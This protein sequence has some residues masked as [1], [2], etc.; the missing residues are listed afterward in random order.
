MW[1]CS[2]LNLR[3]LGL[4]FIRS[5]VG[6]FST[7]ISPLIIVRTSNIKGASLI[8]LTQF[9]LPVSHLGTSGWK[10]R[11]A[12]AKGLTQKINVPT[13]PIV[14]ANDGGVSTI[15]TIVPP[16][17]AAHEIPRDLEGP[18]MARILSPGTSVVFLP[19]L[20]LQS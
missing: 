6:P 8:I 5:T 15:F 2:H 19:E 16:K 3:Y 4:I 17:L 9:H 11:N 10:R 7:N 12:K 18:L 20:I 13:P 14:I 1:N